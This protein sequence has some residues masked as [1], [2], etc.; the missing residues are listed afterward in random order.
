MLNPT[1][2]Q[3]SS[4]YN[5]LRGIK[6]NFISFQHSHLNLLIRILIHFELLKYF[7]FQ[8]KIF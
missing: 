3:P 7:I 8:D 5:Y 1:P 2:Q 6:L 4:I